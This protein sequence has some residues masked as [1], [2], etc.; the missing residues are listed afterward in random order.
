G[1]RTEA[2]VDLW[3]ARGEVNNGCGA[4]YKRTRARHN[5][6]GFCSPSD[7]DSAM[8]E[9]GRGGSTGPP[10]IR[11]KRSTWSAAP[12]REVCGRDDDAE[13]RTRAP[14]FPRIAVG[15]PGG[16]ALPLSRARLL[17]AGRRQAGRV[18]VAGDG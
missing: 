12:I 16:R 2:G 15:A 5:R 13:R 18:L 3:F 1:A 6:D 9:W 14:S 11:R 8:S 4:I 10:P 7:H 17:P